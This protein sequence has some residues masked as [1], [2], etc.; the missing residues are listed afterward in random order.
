MKVHILK[1]YHLVFS[2]WEKIFFSVSV[3][4][5]ASSLQANPVK[6]SATQLVQ[7][8]I[9]SGAYQFLI[10]TIPKEKGQDV[11]EV[12]SKNGKIVLRGNNGVAIASALNYYLREYA[13]AHISWHCADQLN[14]PNPLPLPP[15]KVRIKSPMQYRFAYNYC[16]HGYTMA[17]WG[18]DKWEREIDVLAMQGVNLALVIEGQEQVWID[19]LKSFGYSE[20]EVRKWLCMPSHQPWQ[21][22]SNM[23]NQGKPIP[24]YLVNQ[25]VQLGKKILE[26][27][28]SLG[29]Q[30]LQ[31]GYYGIVPSDF[32]QRFP[33]AKIHKQGFWAQGKLKRPDMLDPTDT[34]FSQVADVF[35]KAQ[36]KLYGKAAFFAADPFHEGG[37]TKGIDLPES[38]RAI[39]AAMKR[40]NA[41]SVW[42]LQSWQRNPRQKMIDALPKEQLLI[43]DLFGEHFENWRT[44]KQ[45]NNT[46]WLW[47][48]VSN[49][50][51]NNG[52]TA[53]FDRIATAPVE[54]FN[55]AGPGH[56]Q[57]RGIGAL[58][59]GSETI[60]MVWE[61]FFSHAWHTEKPKIEEWIRNYARCRYG[62]SSKA[63]EEA[64]SILR[65]TISNAPKESK[66]EYPHN[67]VV[68]ARPS[69]NKKQRARFWTPTT[70]KYYR[71]E[72]FTPAWGKLL[73]AA[74]ECK[75]SDAYQYDLVDFG[76]QVLADLGTRYHIA[77]CDAW[78]AHDS[79]AVGEYSQKFQELIKAMD[80]LVG[81]RKEF[82]V[83]RWISDARQWGSTSEEKALCE[84]SARALITTWTIPESH[85]DYS[86]RE[87][88][89]LLKDFYLKRWTTWYNAVEKGMKNGWT[90]KTDSVYN[91]IVQQ[92]YDW[93]KRNNTYPKIPTGN[94]IDISRKL[95][96]Q[97]SKDALNPSL[98]SH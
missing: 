97:Y 62:A 43:L 48:T 24:G 2:K 55:E 85:T 79:A 53:G 76:R 37:T 30:P 3:L 68:C 51:G 33:N 72:E 40:A 87:W 82:L 83:G 71:S 21:Y 80:K 60:P 47:C 92:D 12:D 61:M 31:Q 29:I 93:V 88:A 5:I 20:L 35:Y 42:V 70:V 59:E 6:K 89:G 11:F 67:S 16:T 36:E 39:Y 28:R 58:M 15:Q 86:N 52:L 95:W 26:R 57:M 78:E 7:R 56:G 23:E 46:P 74:E 65:K 69:F 9:P 17:W 81:T 32:K 77:I 34:L 14:L 27:M 84:Q 50:G 54:A 66:I 25:R 13:H 96:K 45:F 90:L 8:M 63:A 94:S 10:E 91:K 64:L 19:A 44:R 38:G 41:E 49:F 73:E 18:W 22:M 4:L 75:S 1:I 98:Y